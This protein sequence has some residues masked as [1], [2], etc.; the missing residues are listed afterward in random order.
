MGVSTTV[1]RVRKTFYRA[2][3]VD[4]KEVYTPDGVGPPPPE[5]AKA[6]RGNPE[7]IPYFYLAD[8]PETAIREI[9]PKSGDRVWTATYK[10]TKRLK[11]IDLRFGYIRSPFRYAL[12]DLPEMVKKVFLLQH[13]SQDL[14]K[15]VKSKTARLDYLPTQYLCELIKSR[16]YEGILYKSAVGPGSNFMVF[17]DRHFRLVSHNE[18]RYQKNMKLSS[19]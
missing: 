16:A 2:R 8:L 7:G 9:R 10:A 4:E 18:V 5:R 13:L 1:G 6:G 12:K 17:S 11:V 19:T 15:P 14:A 3:I